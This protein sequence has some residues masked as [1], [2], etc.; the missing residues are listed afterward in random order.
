MYRLW[1]GALVTAATISVVAAVVW[2]LLGETWAL[3][4]AAVLLA[5]WVVHHL[6]HLS[7]LERWLRRPEAPAPSGIGHWDE[8]FAL[9]FRRERARQ[10][11]IA[12]LE[13]SLARM[14]EASQAMPDG[15]VILTAD[16]AIEWLNATAERHLGLNAETDR[17]MSIL[18]LV[19]QPDFVAYLRAG[20]YAQPLRLRLIRQPATTLQLKV[21]RFAED[22]RLLLTRDV[23]LE[24]RLD[25]MRRDFVAN[26]SHELK[27][28]LTVVTGFLETLD[29]ALPDLDA[30]TARRYIGLAHDQAGRMQRLVDDLLTL[31]SLDTGSPLPDEEDVPLG[32]LLEAIRAEMEALSGGRHTI[33][34]H[35]EGSEALYGSAKELRSAFANLVSNA[36]RYTPAGGHIHM[37]WRGGPGGGEFEVQDDGIG[38][39]PEH[40]PRL[41][42]RF[43]RVDRSR[44]RET[45][46]TGLGL[47]IV[48]HVLERHQAV[49]AVHSEVGRG[50]RF[51]VRFPARRVQAGRAQSTA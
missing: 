37:R 48:K 7:R 3:G 33:T 28:P 47:A 6:N 50:S 17:G 24:E 41:T 32:P 15:T 39:A 9:L 10:Q 44:S 19:R 26:V 49:L 25:T 30:D 12:A 34:L 35:L 45:G 31:A 20:D 16:D 11:R 4:V 1:I 8:M 29:D 38:I 36:V 13:V 27:T 21:V 46:G 40:V 51:T 43:Y 14:R 18:N 22:R 5:A 42:E 23:S 2:A